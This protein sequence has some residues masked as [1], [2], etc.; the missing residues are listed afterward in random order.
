MY[1]TYDIKSI[2]SF[3]FRI[4]RLRDIVGGSALVDYFDRKEAKAF[5]VKGVVNHLFSG[6]GKGAFSCQDK[7]VALKLRDQLL[8]K[9]HE[10]GF[11]IAFGCNSDYSEAAH[12][13]DDLFPFLPLQMEGHPCP[14]SGLY[15]VNDNRPLA[16]REEHDMVKLR[17]AEKYRFHYEQEFRKDL[18]LPSHLSQYEPVFFHDVDGA[19]Q[20]KVSRQPNLHDGRC[21]AEAIGGRNRWAIVAMDGND[22]G[23]QFRKQSEK[24]NHQIPQEWIRHMSQ[25][26]DRITRTAFLAGL[27]TVIDSWGQDEKDGKKECVHKNALHLPIRPLVVGGDDIIVLCHGSYGLEFVKAVCK[28]FR[29]TSAKAHQ[30]WKGHAQNQQKT[31]LWPATGGELTIS[32]GVLFAPVSLPLATAI[33]YAESLLASAKHRGRSEAQGEGKPSPECLDWEFITSSLLE[34]PATSRQRDFLFIDEDLNEEVSLT[35]RPYTL[36]NFLELENLCDRYAKKDEFPRQLVHQT[37]VELNKS[38][39]QRRVY[40]ARIAKS[41]PAL[42]EDLFEPEDLGKKHSSR[43]QVSRVVSGKKGEGAQKGRET[44]VLDALLLLEEGHRMSKTTAFGSRSLK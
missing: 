34:H 17:R 11:D 22:M 28:S 33:P 15:P 13:A 21:G 36:K 27:Q 16:E 31:E 1:L 8:K 10:F 32:A 9:A 6:G 3:I 25:E 24:F 38:Y 39:W 20:A 5:E 26:L 43:W 44:D 2:Q 18:R 7:A 41:H 4:P 12:C 42:Y 37:M 23:A 29:E 40:M 19:S 14:E 30:E 35:C